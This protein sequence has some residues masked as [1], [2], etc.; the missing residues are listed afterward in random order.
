[1][2][3]NSS[4]EVQSGHLADDIHLPGTAKI[5]LVE[6]IEQELPRWRDHPDRP[7][8]EAEAVLTEHLCDHLNSAVYDSEA[9]SHV[10]FRTEIVDETDGGRKIDLAVKPRR[11][12]I[13]IE[14]RR[15]SLFDALFPI[16]CKRLPTPHGKNRDE[17]EYV[18]TRNGTT[19]GIQRFK[20]GHHGAAHKFAAMIGYVQAKA[21]SE[22]LTVMNGWIVSLSAE[23]ESVWTD[24]DCLRSSHENSAGKVYTAL[25]NHERP[26]G[27]GPCE[28]RH[29]WVSM[30]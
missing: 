11:K 29:L 17:R 28:L 16:E 15:H 25:S 30:N 1:M 14:A 7:H 21:F 3:A 8:A 9:W 22:W 10:Q 6:F 24:A 4:H 18:I 27:L 5:E 26:D 19:G 23:P 20:F 12:S 2:L 13:V